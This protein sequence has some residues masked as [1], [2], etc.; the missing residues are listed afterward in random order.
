MR[1]VNRSL[2]ALATLAALIGLLAV[3]PTL[4]AE[5]TLTAALVGGAA[6]T[7]TGDPDGTGSATITIDPVTNEVCWDFTTANIAASVVSHI[8]VGAAGVTGGVVVGLDL[9][10]FSGTSAGCVTDTAADLE[11]I[12]ANPA[13]FYVNIHTAD[14]PAGAIRGQLAAGAAPPDT[15][16][17]RSTT[18]L[19]AL[20]AMVLLIGLAAGLRSVRARA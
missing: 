14:Y 6:E 16:M 4:A 19:V 10:G 9:D 1:T 17:A 12:L 8:H 5:T 2:V 20:G 15:A 18:P 13:G 7:P 11:A 3:G